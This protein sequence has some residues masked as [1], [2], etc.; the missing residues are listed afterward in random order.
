MTGSHIARLTS[1]LRSPE[2]ANWLERNAD[3]LDAG[4]T[5]AP[6]VLPELGRS[7]VFR[8]GVSSHAGGTGASIAEAIEAVADVAEYSLTAAFVFWG[9]RTFIEYVVQSSNT[10]LRDRWLPS[11]LSGE[12]AGATGLSNAMKYLSA[13]EKLQMTAQPHKDG[14]KL[15]GGLPWITNLRKE[16][17]LAAAAFENGD[18]RKPSIIAI[19]SDIPG[20]ERSEDLDLIALRSSNTA[21]LRLNGATV[22]DEFLIADDAPAFLSRVRPAFLGL[23]CGMS[24]GLAR[25][26]LGEVFATSPASR[27]AVQAEAE[28]LKEKVELLSATLKSDVVSGRS[29]ADPSSLFELRIALA[30]ATDAAVRLEV[31]ATGG[32]GYLRGQSGAARRT[33]EAAF[34]PIVTPS[35]VQ[36]KSQLLQHKR[37]QAA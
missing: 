26:A 30:Y 9:Q 33:R 4:Q 12:M 32:R 29:L 21:A 18:G 37:S 28:S 19:S 15:N 36:L 14:W 31:Q 3:E 10:G 22:G 25:R 20:V 8:I 16:G 5:L 11:L 7:G 13:I 2:L 17:F 1:E 24:V 27:A 6:H 23:Q 35:L 34:I